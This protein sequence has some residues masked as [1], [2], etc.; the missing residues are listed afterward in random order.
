MIL[1]HGSPA[2]FDAFSLRWAGNGTGINFGYGVYLTEVEASAVHYS[3][4]RKMELTPEHYLYT[5]EIPDLTSDNHLVSALPVEPSIIKK[6]EDKLGTAAPETAKAKGKVFRKWVGATILKQKYDNDKF[7]AEK[8]AAELLNSLGVLYNVW[9]HA[10]TK[11]DGPKKI[12]VFDAANVTIVKRERIEIENK[13][14]KWVLTGRKE[15]LPPDSENLSLDFVDFDIDSIPEEE[16]F[17]SYVSYKDKTYTFK[18]SG[19][20]SYN[21]EM[22]NE[23]KITL[24]PKEVIS[25]RQWFWNRNLKWIG[26]VPSEFRDHNPELYDKL[27]MAEVDFINQSDPLEDWEIDLFKG[28][29]DPDSKIEY[30][31]S[32][33]VSDINCPIEP[34]KWPKQLFEEMDIT[35][36]NISIW[37][38]EKDGEAKPG[39]AGYPIY[40]EERFV[41]VL[42]EIVESKICNSS[43]SY[44]N[45]DC[46]KETYPELYA[47][48]KE[49]IDEWLPENG[50]NIKDSNLT[51]SLYQLT[52]IKK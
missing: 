36:P 34:L 17:T 40:I 9:P 52:I 3:Q 43:T 46:L 24:S 11:P 39:G 38:Q 25:I 33:D 1:Y 5:V 28:D 41:P 13:R 19:Y 10:Q 49:G 31:P 15:I 4:P 20:Y 50:V 45:I 51:Y 44:V 14:K 2:L 6:V 37:V 12:A 42:E 26:Y 48:I 47:A 18:T 8:A 7:A 22:V 23:I 32:Y 30:D 27:Y 35:C 29:Y 21:G 16:L